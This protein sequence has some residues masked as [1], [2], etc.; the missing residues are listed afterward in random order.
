[1]WAAA[2]LANILFVAIHPINTHICRTPCRHSACSN[3]PWHSL[4]SVLLADTLSTLSLRRSLLTLSPQRSYTTPIIVHAIHNI[5]IGLAHSGYWGRRKNLCDRRRGKLP[6]QTTMN[7]KLQASS[8]TTMKQRFLGNREW[9]AHDARSW[10]QNK[11]VVRVRRLTSADAT[12][13]SCQ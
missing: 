9:R 5:G 1:M 6:L 2:L 4:R 10:N 3:P 8:P 7:S 12:C 13:S 11:N